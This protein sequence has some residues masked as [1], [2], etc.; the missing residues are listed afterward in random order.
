MWVDEGLRWTSHIQKVS[1][2]IGRLVGIM[3]RVA[4]VLGSEQLLTLYNALVLP[5]LQY[6]LIA[7]GDFK[8]G[9]NKLL[10][11]TLLRHQKKLARLIEGGKRCHADPIFGQRG[12]L[13]I[14]DL[15]R[16]QLRTH[17]W[18]FRN[19]RL[20]ENQAELLGKTE[21][22][23][24]HNT[25]A[26]RAG[27]YVSTRDHRAVGYR[28]P[29]EWDTLPHE[30]KTTKSL[31]TFKRKSKEGFL[32]EYKGFRCRVEGCYVCGEGGNGE[33]SNAVH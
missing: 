30:M 24:S 33:L 32:T 25:R 13:K 28:I 17:A 5:H 15:Y 19:D 20:P 21:E 2:K 18:M 12:I 7:W 6:C 11:D 16:Q 10:G 14:N 27:L 29:K 26:A 4:S 22:V 1:G 31:T 8:E 3:G 23:H 9:R